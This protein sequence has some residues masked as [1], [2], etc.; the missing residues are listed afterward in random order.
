MNDDK[1]RKLSLDL[2]EISEIA[3]L[4]TVNEKGYPNTRAM[5]NLRRHVQFPDI[6]QYLEKNEED[7]TVYFSTNTS[8]EKIE[9]ARANP[10]VS[11]YY[12]L[13]G[14]FR[15]LMLSGDI[16][17]VSDENIREN[18]WQAG[19]EMYYPKGP[20]DPDHTVLR[21]FPAFAKYYHKLETFCFYPG[22]ETQ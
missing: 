20:R 9:E 18:I 14:E 5:F 1:A 12:S 8:S 6:S 16:E 22:G 13:P 4:T 2:M 17:P 15:G 19:W 21:I 7:F 10:K 11:V 3:V